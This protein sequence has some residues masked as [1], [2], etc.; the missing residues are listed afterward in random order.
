M[1]LYKI[2]SIADTGLDSR[3]ASHTYAAYRKHFSSDTIGVPSPDFL[4]AGGCCILAGIARRAGLAIL[5]RRRG[6]RRC[7][8][9]QRKRE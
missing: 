3:K 2:F 6:R 5:I 4:A 7:K 1:S 9:H 8:S